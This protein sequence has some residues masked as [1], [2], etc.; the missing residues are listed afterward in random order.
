MAA[1]GNAR[2]MAALTQALRRILGATRPRGTDVGIGGEARQRRRAINA[3]H[4]I[5]RSQQGTT[6]TTLTTANIESH[7][8]RRRPELQER[9]LVVV[10][11]E[12]VMSPRAGGSSPLIRLHFPFV[13]QRP[14]TNRAYRSLRFACRRMVW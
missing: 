12:C 5:A 8:T 3:Q 2:K 11:V 9:R 14:R 6:E 4:L 13:A 10:P 7:A 1:A